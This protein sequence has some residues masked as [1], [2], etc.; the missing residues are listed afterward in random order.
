MICPDSFKGTLTAREAAGAISEGIRRANPTAETI[1]CP[2]GDGGEGTVDALTS[3]LPDIEIVDCETTDPLHRPITAGYAI[4]GGKT[5]LIES[6]AASGLTLVAEEDRDIMN[7]DTYGTGIL[8]ADAYKKGIREFIICMGGTATCDGGY[9]A[10]KAL[11]DSGVYNG[12]REGTA[13]T[14][15]TDVDNPFCGP[16]GAAAVF[17]PQKGAV[18]EQI[19]LLEQRLRR[20]AGEYAMAAGTDVTL[21]K[22]AG[23]AGGLAGMLMAC[24]GAK[25]VSGIDKVIE[26]LDIRSKAQGADMIITGEGKADMTTLRG[27]AAK[28]ILD[29]GLDCRIPVALIAGRVTH[30][31]MLLEAGFCN[32]VQATPDDAD[33]GISKREYLARGAMKLME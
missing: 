15:L 23:A 25:P 6:A 19:P 14:L 32:V 9:G 10:L 29:V 4:A 27:K 13:I 17:G 7:A 22:F 16:E 28:G 1:L 18:E 24:C 3:V 20:L 30:R 12:I 33:P 31:E 5:A 8:I 21:S 11:R 2:V 26:L